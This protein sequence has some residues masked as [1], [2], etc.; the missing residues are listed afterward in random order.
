[1]EEVVYNDI[2]KVAQFCNQHS[3]SG[4]NPNLQLPVIYW[5][6]VQVG[7]LEGFPTWRSVVESRGAC[8]TSSTASFSVPKSHC[9]PPSLPC[10]SAEK[11][12]QEREE[13][14]LSHNTA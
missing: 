14:V 10:S 11:V 4:K 3:F 9:V 2:L 8:I 1:M 7:Q 12:T 5:L 13:L 6:N